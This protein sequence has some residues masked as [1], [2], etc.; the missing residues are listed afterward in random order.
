MSNMEPQNN[1][2]KAKANM[3]FSAVFA[4]TSKSS[5][6]KYRNLYYGNVSFGQVLWAELVVTLVGGMQGALGLW[7]RSKLYPSL[8]KSCGRGVVFGKN[9]TIRHPA[10]I[11]IGDNVVLD[12]NSVVDAKGETN[13]GI[14]IG[15]NVFIGRNSIVYCKDGD[16]EIRDRVSIASDCTIMSAYRITIKEDVMI[17]GYTYI[18]SGGDYDYANKEI[19][20]WD[21]GG[22]PS[23]GELTIGHNCWIGARVTILDAAS[24]GDN[25]VIG[26]SSLVN[27]PVPS[28]SLAY[29][30]P[31]KVM[32]SI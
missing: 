31:A 9:M 4:D 5:A 21:K 12:D 20:F 6:Q 30:V 19:L 18:L 28:N 23:R 7:L 1:T 8:F 24:I 26:A 3:K 15:N 22:A 2:D 25:C 29:G 11:S 17:G 27:K 16:T 32:K 13:K 14:V 10:K